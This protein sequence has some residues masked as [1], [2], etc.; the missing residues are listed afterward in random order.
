MAARR[1]AASRRRRAHLLTPGCHERSRDEAAAAAHA[2]R[3]LGLQRRRPRRA[4]QR[5]EAPADRSRAP[6]QGEAETCADTYV[7]G[8]SVL[9]VRATRTSLLRAVSKAQ[10]SLPRGSLG[11]CQPRA[12]RLIPRPW[13]H[14]RRRAKEDAEWSTLYRLTCLL[15]ALVVGFSPLLMVAAY[16]LMVGLGQEDGGKC[17]YVRHAGLEPDRQTGRETH[18][19]SRGPRTSGPLA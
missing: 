14:R 15:V 10:G 2:E 13:Q 6:L 5:G 7:P 16:F 9:H 11:A 4:A 18:G 17:S 19:L 12:C 8:A 1:R 3:A